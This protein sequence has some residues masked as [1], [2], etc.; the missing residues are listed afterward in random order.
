[1]NRDCSWKETQTRKKTYEGIK[2]D[3]SASQFGLQKL[4]KELDQ[5]IENSSPY[6]DLIFPRYQNLV[7]ELG[8]HPSLHSIDM[9]YKDK[10]DLFNNFLA[11]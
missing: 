11:N 10:A 3:A 2:I 5:I 8:V 7:L 1:M 4:I 6:I 9:Q